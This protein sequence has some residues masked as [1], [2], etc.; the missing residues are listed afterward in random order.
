MRRE[1]ITAPLK[2]WAHGAMWKQVVVI[3]STCPRAS[4][5]GWIQCELYY[6]LAV[7]LQGS[8]TA[9]L[10]FCV[11][12]CKK[13]RMLVCLHGSFS[14]IKWV[15]TVRGFGAVPGPQLLQKTR[16]VT[17]SGPGEWEALDQIEI[18]VLNRN[19]F[20]PERLQHKYLYVFLRNK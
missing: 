1:F 13:E 17:L 3:K 8:E 18:L 20:S 9:T 2:F 10:C 19:L 5:G 11:C 16:H 6:F 7:W 4:P 12:L 15:C 14:K